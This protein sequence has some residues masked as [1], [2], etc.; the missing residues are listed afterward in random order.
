MDMVT[1]VMLLICPW[2]QKK[3]V[4]E[5]RCDCILFHRDILLVAQHCHASHLPVTISCKKPA[6]V[7]TTHFPSSIPLL[8]FLYPLFI[9]IRHLLPHLTQSIAML[10]D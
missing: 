3:E 1:V 6:Y 8:G 4:E 9:L 7:P 2:L 5:L 10:S